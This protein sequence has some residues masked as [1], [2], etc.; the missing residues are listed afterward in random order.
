MTVAA[1][2][3]FAQGLCAALAISWPAFDAQITVESNWTATAVSRAGAEGIAQI[4]PRWHPQAEGHTFDPEW[5][6]RYAARWMS[7]LIH[8]RG[9][10]YRE[11]LA[12]YN[13]GPNS[14]GA[15]RQQ[16]YDYADK[17]LE[18]AYPNKGSPSG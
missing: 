6:L 17:I 10:N 11:A 3:V 8:S 12:D 5:S 9:G 14:T 7:Q 18:M 13:T 1:L 4:I 15:F 16:G 2:K